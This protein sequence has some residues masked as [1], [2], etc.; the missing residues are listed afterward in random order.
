M[1]FLKVSLLYKF[2]EIMDNGHIKTPKLNITGIYIV[3]IHVTLMEDI[4]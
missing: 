1:L 3:C 2:L 4:I